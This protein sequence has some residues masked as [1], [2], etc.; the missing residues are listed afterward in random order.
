MSPVLKWIG[1]VLIV[2]AGG[3]FGYRL[4]ASHKQE[5][6][7]LR[8][9]IGALDYMQCELQYHLTPL[10]DLCRQAGEQYRDLIGQVLLML[11]AELE[12]RVSPDVESCVRDTL[13]QARELPERTK[14]AF[15]VLGASLGRFDVEGQI[16]GLEGV[17]SFCRMELD[18]LSQNRDVRLR[19]YQTL[20]LCAGAA[21]A[22]LF[23]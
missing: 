11:A 19:S 7:A 1:A 15:Q 22:I 12:C 5:E 21:I 9:M 13:C 18:S 20:G 2:A 4:A 8:R 23:V 10:P 16:R 6:K 14:K 17:R 3:L